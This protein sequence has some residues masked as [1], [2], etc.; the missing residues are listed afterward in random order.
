MVRTTS[1]WWKAILSI[2]LRYSIIA[3]CWCAYLGYRYDSFDAERT[4]MKHR[5]PETGQWISHEEWLKLQ[6]QEMPEHPDFDDWDDFEDFDQ[7]D[8]LGYDEEPS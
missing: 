2:I 5:H 4:K 3:F 8:E 7:F 1:T 6:K